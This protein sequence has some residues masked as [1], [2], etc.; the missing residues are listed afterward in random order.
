MVNHRWQ[1]L[2]S[3][4]WRPTRPL[5]LGGG[6]QLAGHRAEPD[7]SGNLQNFS[8]HRSEAASVALPITEYGFGR[9]DGYI[10]LYRAGVPPV[11]LI[12]KSSFSTLGKTP[13]Y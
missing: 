4:R 6:G 11:R 3:R 9:M 2:Y 12:M 8:E 1:K 10:L 7:A 5:T 13:I